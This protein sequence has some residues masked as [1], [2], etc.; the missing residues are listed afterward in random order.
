MF[1]TEWNNT[2]DNYV[3]YKYDS[4]VNI[5]RNYYCMNHCCSINGIDM[6]NVM[7]TV[8]S[9]CVGIACCVNIY[10]IIDEIDK[11]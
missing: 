1:I 6:Y 4:N 8:I 9:S 10:D 11:V 2:T 3:K 5:L 7:L